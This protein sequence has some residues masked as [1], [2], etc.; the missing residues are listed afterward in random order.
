MKKPNLGV[1]KFNFSLGVLSNS[2]CNFAC[3]FVKFLVY[4]S[5]C[6]LR[7]ALKS[8]KYRHERQLKVFRTKIDIKNRS[9]GHFAG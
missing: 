3:N 8:D 4:G 7:C 1:S 2:K 5:K 9:M 6:R